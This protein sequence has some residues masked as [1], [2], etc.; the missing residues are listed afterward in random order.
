MT[1]KK[2]MKPPARTCYQQRKKVRNHA[3]DQ[4]K[5]LKFFSYT[6]KKKSPSQSGCF[7]TNISLC[8]VRGADFVV[9]TNQDYHFFTS[10]INQHKP[11]K[12]ISC[13]NYIDSVVFMCS[14]SILFILAPI[15]LIAIYVLFVYIIAILKS[16]L[17]IISNTRF[18]SLF[19]PIRP[20]GAFFIITAELQG[21]QENLCFFLIHSNATPAS[22]KITQI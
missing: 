4:E 14:F 11:T 18:L 2:S 7:T 3:L 13:I 9:S 5:K 22:R 17:L 15:C 20:V 1:K 21:V 19:T 6:N 16:V 12:F 8:R 10:P